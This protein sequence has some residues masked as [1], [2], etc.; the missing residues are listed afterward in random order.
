MINNVKILAYRCVRFPSNEK[1]NSCTNWILL[2]L[3]SLQEEEGVGLN[4]TWSYTIY[5]RTHALTHTGLKSHTLVIPGHP[6]ELSST[7]I[8]RNL[9]PTQSIVASCKLQMQLSGQE[10]S[11]GNWAVPKA[12]KLRTAI[13]RKSICNFFSLYI[14]RH[15]AKTKSFC[16]K[17]TSLV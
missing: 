4:I 7:G 15:A 3:R 1:A 14:R 10:H 12:I 2:S 6:Q 16:P 13:S 5:P 11:R 17:A 8:C 9:W